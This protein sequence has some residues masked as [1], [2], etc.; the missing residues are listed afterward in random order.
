[1]SEKAVLGFGSDSMVR[2]TKT[3]SV[4][5]SEGKKIKIKA[6]SIGIPDSSAVDEDGHQHVHFEVGAMTPCVRFPVEALLPA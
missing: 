3:M 2:A 1:M 5:S 4:Y 6:H